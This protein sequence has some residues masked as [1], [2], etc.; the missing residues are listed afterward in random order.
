MV[1]N[2]DQSLYEAAKISAISLI[3]Q[4]VLVFFEFLVMLAVTKG[5]PSPE[6]IGFTS[7]IS[8]VSVMWNQW[9]RTSSFNGLKHENLLNQK[10]QLRLLRSNLSEW[11]S[12][13]RENLSQQIDL[14]DTDFR[15]ANLRGADLSDVNFSKANF[16]RAILSEANFRGADFSRA[17]LREA[18]LLDTDLREAIFSGAILCETNLRGADLRDANLVDADL[19]LANF[20]NAI[21]QNCNFGNGLGLSEAQKADLKQRGAIFNDNLG[22][23]H[24]TDLPGPSD[25]PIDAND[26]L[27]RLVENAAKQLPVDQIETD[28]SAWKNTHEHI[29]QKMPEPMDWE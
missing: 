6:I 4:T 18:V 10:N 21:V 1:K 27:I 12:W 2:L 8:I 15:N 22:A 16:R 3:S 7:C 29:P 20:E 17:I 9:D 5:E 26:A 25:P 19:M 13:R 24:T 28:S 14:N 23:S 11:N